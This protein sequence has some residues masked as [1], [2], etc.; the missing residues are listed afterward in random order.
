MSTITES[1]TAPFAPRVVA[2]EITGA[3]Q[4]Q[5][6][7]CFAESG[8]SGAHGAMTVD[9][10]RRVISEA[11]SLGAREVQLIGGEP[12]THPAWP[13]LV[14]HAL[15]L[16]LCVEVYSNLFHVRSDWWSLFTRQGVKLATSYYSDRASEHDVITTRPGS[17]LRTRANIAEAVRR[18][19]PLRVGIVSVLPRQRVTEACQELRALGVRLIR[20]DRA[21]RIGRAALPVG[22]VTPSELCGHCGHGQ[23]AVL[24]SG[25][26]A[27][28]VMARW[29]L[30]GNVRQHSLGAILNSSTWRQALARVPA[31][32]H[33]PCDPE[34]NPASDGSDCAPAEQEACNPKYDE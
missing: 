31:R 28:C 18:G 30:A 13:E 5:C 33:S 22:T 15:D 21:R 17:Y 12:T 16:R 7:T 25:E 23:A 19:V 26:V 24:P 32:A 29:L 14:E 3:C 9:D 1:R 27:P 8:P 11:A 10:W 2:L 4:L 6:V 20:T 34:C